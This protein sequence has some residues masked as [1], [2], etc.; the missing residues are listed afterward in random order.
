MSPRVTWTWL[1]ADTISLIAARRWFGTEPQD[2]VTLERRSHSMG[3]DADT[4]ALALP[5]RFMAPFL[6][7]SLPEKEFVRNLRRIQ[8]RQGLQGPTSQAARCVRTVL[9]ECL[10]VRLGVQACTQQSIQLSTAG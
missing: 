1:V 3:N 2:T 4:T 7:G 8:V 9:P 6:T 5:E 10:C